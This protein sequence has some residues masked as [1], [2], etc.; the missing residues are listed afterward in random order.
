VWGKLADDAWAVFPHQLFETLYPELVES[1]SDDV[2]LWAAADSEAAASTTASAAVVPGDDDD[3]SEDERSSDPED[4]QAEEEQQGL[5]NILLRKK[6]RELVHEA[7]ERVRNLFEMKSQVNTRDALLFWKRAFR[8]AESAP[9][10]KSILL[11]KPL[12]LGY[13][14]AQP[15]QALQNRPFRWPGP[16]NRRNARA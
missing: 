13:L 7:L 11:L 1:H 6:Q 8:H 16:P 9:A 4:K 14:P 3:D 5:G 15:H 12:V 10:Y 2:N